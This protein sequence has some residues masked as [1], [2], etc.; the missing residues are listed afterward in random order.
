MVA[1][2]GPD[3][4]VI[5]SFS[6]LEVVVLCIGNPFFNNYIFITQHHYTILC[7]SL[8]LRFFFISRTYISHITTSIQLKNSMMFGGFIEILRT[9]AVVQKLK[10]AMKGLDLK[11]V[12]AAV[13]LLGTVC[14]AASQEKADG[15]GA[16][17]APQVEVDANGLFTVEDCPTVYDR[18]NIVFHVSDYVISSADILWDGV[19]CQTVSFDNDNDCVTRMAV[20]YLDANFD[21]YL[22]ILLGAGT[23]REYSALL[24]W[25]EEENM[26]VRA[27]NDGF[28]I[29]NGDFFYNPERMVVYR[30]TSSCYAET[31][32]T[33]MVW[34]GSDLQSEETFLIITDESYYDDYHVTHCYTVRN[35]YSDEDI[36]STDDPS[37]FDGDWTQ[38]AIKSVTSP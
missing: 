34:Q 8:V 15:R 33:M 11:T 22:D 31:T 7:E 20:H 14:N 3:T 32:Y 28:S 29:F 27:T 18:F 37:R 9:F 13:A 21:G 2:F 38:W 10:K 19:E 5:T 4:F 16:L 30:R 1:F 23:N 26:F 12:L 25:N 17:A 6:F 24:L 35:Y 36:I